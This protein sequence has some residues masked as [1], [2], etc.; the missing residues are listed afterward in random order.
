MTDQH[1][2]KADL[3][4]LMV[5]L[6]A[7]FGWMF[8]KE[9]MQGLPPLLFLGLR[10]LLAGLL[11][12]LIGWRE[13]GRLE[14]GQWWRAGATG[15]TFGATLVCWILALYHAD[16]LGVGAFITS[17][18]VILAPVVGRALFGV[19][20]RPATWLA[21][22]VATAGLACLSLDGG[23]RVGLAELL[24]IVSAFGF[25]LH[26]NLNTRF[27][28]RIPV[29]ALA[30]IQLGIVGV[31]GLL[32]S[33]AAEDWPGAVRGEILAWLVASIVL[34]TSLRFFLQ[35]KAQGIVPLSHAALIMTLEPVWTGLIAMVWL[36]ERMSGVEFS[37]CSL[38]F[39][40]LLVDR[41][42]LIRR[43][44]RPGRKQARA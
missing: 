11:L 31:M 18:G 17:L 26:F 14:L 30:A 37:G 43:W 39:L 36:G 41:W 12:G 24:F 8:S 23:A 5:T 40:A 15:L 16:R 35:I 21:V 10:F 4:M 44:V 3:L 6:L 32:L 27:A 28:P 20:V 2:L 19:L 29:L 7:A 9:A 13:L 25:A 38:I 33:F 1:H 42:A 22:G 34:A